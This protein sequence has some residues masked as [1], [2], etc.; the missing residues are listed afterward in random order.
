MN[1]MKIIPVLLIMMSVE[2]Y[3]QQVK[4]GYV[5]KVKVLTELDSWKD[6]DKRLMK[7]KEDAEYELIGMTT[8]ADSLNKVLQNQMMLTDAM[9]TQIQ[10]RIVKL[11]QDYQRVGVTRQQELI[12]TENSLKSPILKAFD[13]IVRDLGIKE[14]FTFIYDN[15][16]NSIMFASGGRDLT[17]QVL[18]ELRK[19]YK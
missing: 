16:I 10:S 13:E 19:N 1:K 9:R 11:S 4:I 5:D 15:T 18:F 3:S 6:A 12:Q 8:E 2:A 14:D 7:M 17:E